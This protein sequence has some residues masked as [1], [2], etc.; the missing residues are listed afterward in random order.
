[1]YQ[2]SNKKIGASMLIKC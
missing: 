1:M 2:G